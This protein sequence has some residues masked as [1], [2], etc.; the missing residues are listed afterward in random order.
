[1]ARQD[2]LVL[3]LP[4]FRK[5][6]ALMS[7]SDQPRF[8][9]FVFP[10]TLYLL[11]LHICNPIVTLTDEGDTLNGSYLIKLHFSYLNLKI[12]WGKICLKC[13]FIKQSWLTPLACDQRQCIKDVSYSISIEYKGVHNCTTCCLSTRRLV[14][15]DSRLASI[16][17]GCFVVRM[18]QQALIDM[19]NMFDLLNEKQEVGLSKLSSS[20][21]SEA[22]PIIWG[23]RCSCSPPSSILPCSLSY[24]L[25]AQQS[26][27]LRP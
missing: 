9:M 22:C 21:L 2:R 1:M 11:Q 20:S 10:K 25:P 23:P 13:P 24:S 12:M 19:E 17:N 16:D 8:P 6:L 27:I 14:V 5:L 26:L 3:A 4:V 15:V 18:I 7:N